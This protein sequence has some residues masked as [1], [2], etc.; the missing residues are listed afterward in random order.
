MAREDA[1]PFKT[2]A[3]Q[4][5]RDYLELDDTTP[6]FRFF[7]LRQDF[8]TDWY[9]FLNPTNPANGNVFELEMSPNLFRLLDTGKT[10]KIN[11]ISLLVAVLM[12][13]HTRS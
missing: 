3:I 1:G 4:S 13:A 12:T 2:A 8:P 7:D 6:S 9:R 11:S 5:L 10:L